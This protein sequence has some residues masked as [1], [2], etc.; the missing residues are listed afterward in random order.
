MGSQ[1]FSRQIDE[2]FCFKTLNFFVF[3]I[4]QID[5]GLYTILDSKV[6]PYASFFLIQSFKKGTYL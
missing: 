4:V 5:V 1:E 3:T 6:I 2:C